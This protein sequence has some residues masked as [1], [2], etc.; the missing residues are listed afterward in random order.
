MKKIIY[1]AATALLLT[2]CGGGKDPVS[3]ATNF[4]NA[5]YTADQDDMIRYLNE[6]GKTLMTKQMA[7]TEDI[8]QDMLDEMASDWGDLGYDVDFFREIGYTTHFA[9]HDIVY[10]E[11]E[12]ELGESEATVVFDVTSPNFEGWSGKSVIPLARNDEGKWAVVLGYGFDVEYEKYDRDLTWKLDFP[13]ATAEWDAPHLNKPF[14]EHSADI[15]KA[16]QQF[17]DALCKFDFEA[18]NKLMVV[19]EFSPPGKMLEL[20]KRVY[21]EMKRFYT[22]A[23]V[24]AELYLVYYSDVAADVSFDL[25]DDKKLTI[26]MMKKGNKWLVHDFE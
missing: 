11:G 15:R 26:E 18:C 17:A 6:K 4:L 13:T 3:V 25:S 23:D 19:G 7:E 20:E 8:F 14:T 5:F 9:R 24:A 22:T 10:N 1:I 21:D 12:S 16:A 2:A